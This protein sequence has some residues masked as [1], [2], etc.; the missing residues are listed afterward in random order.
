MKRALCERRERADVLDLI[1]EEL[2]AKRLASGAGED[3]DEPSADRDLAALLG[4]LDTLVAGEREGFDEAVEPGSSP[5]SRR[6]IPGRFSTGGIPSASAR[7]ETQTRPPSART[8]S[9]RA[10]S[11]T[12]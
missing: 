6:T 12:R 11:P 7:A 9:A 2:D 5:G 10:R 1:P 3:V 4:P 8:A